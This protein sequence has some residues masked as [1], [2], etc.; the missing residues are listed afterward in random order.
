V[1]QVVRALWD[2]WDST[3]FIGVYKEE[4]VLLLTRRDTST[5]RIRVW[6]PLA[7]YKVL[8]VYSVWPT[9]CFPG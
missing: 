5:Y 2:A 4:R 8:H 6:G 1:W 7:V 9:T 3:L